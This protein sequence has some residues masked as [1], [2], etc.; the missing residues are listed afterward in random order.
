MIEMVLANEVH[1]VTIKWLVH[2]MARHAWDGI[3]V[4]LLLWYC[5]DG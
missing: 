2:T 1:T 3:A 5:G 4:H